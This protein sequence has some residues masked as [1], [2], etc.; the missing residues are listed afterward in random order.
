MS[1]HGPTAPPP[2]R[3][4]AV[5]GRAGVPAQHVARADAMRTAL[6]LLFLLALAAMPGALLPQRPLNEPKVEQYI[7]DHGWW[8]R[9]LDKLQF[10]GVYGS[11]W[12]AA[13]YVL[14]FVSLVG[15]LLPRTVDYSRQLFAKPV[16]TP[17][18]LARLP[19]HV[20]AELT[21]A[22]DAMPWPDAVRAQAARLA[23][24]RGATRAAASSRCPASAVSC[25]RPATWCSTSRCSG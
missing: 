6:V 5:R 14:L 2:P 9:L 17:R 23:G 13:I 4:G 1:R 20:R 8:G 16:I 7:A 18:N 11:V 10:F 21:G 25:G 12:F 24:G 22:P 19:H 3:Q 15:C